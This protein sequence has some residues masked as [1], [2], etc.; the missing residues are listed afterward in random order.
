M[1]VDRGIGIGI[2]IGICMNNSR[3]R[4]NVTIH[5]ANTD[6]EVRD[7]DHGHDQ[8]DTSYYGTTTCHYYHANTNNVGVLGSG[9]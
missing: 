3:F 8:E 4:S 5:D 9:K 6:W 7:E 1:D 2:D